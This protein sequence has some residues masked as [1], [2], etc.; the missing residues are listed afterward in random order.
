MKKVAI[1]PR[2]FLAALLLSGL[3]SFGAS[4]AP[5]SA[6]AGSIQE[7]TRFV[8]P[9]REETAP[10]SAYV[11]P[12]T[13]SAQPALKVALQGSAPNARQPNTPMLASC[14]LTVL[15]QDNSTSGNERAPTLRNR[16]ARSVYLI[17]AAELAANGLS[18]GAT[19]TGIGWDYQTAQGVTGSGPLVVYMQNT[20]DVTNTKSTTWA[21]AITGMTTVHNATTTLPSPAGTFDIP[22]SGGSPFTYTGGGIYV[23]F[24]FQYPVGTLST[25]TVVWCNSTGLVNGLL[26]NQSNASAPTTLAASSF[27]PETRL[28]ATVPDND[29]SVDVI[30]SIGT[31]AIGLEQPH[32][33]QAVITNKG[34]T[35]ISNLPVTLSI[36]GAESFTDTQVIPSL[37]A[38]GGQTTVSFAAFTPAVQ[39]SDVVTVSVPSDD[40]PA[41]NTKTRPLNVTLP[42]YSY[43]YPGSVMAGGFGFTGATGAFVAKFSTTAPAKITDVNLEFAG[44]NTGYRVAIYAN[45]GGPGV[46]G[47]LVYLDA[48]N[49][50]TGGAGPVTATLS[51]PVTIGPG[52]FFVGIH[53]MNTT[54]ANL[55]FDLEAPIRAG[56]F[57]LGTN[58][59]ATNPPGTWTDFFPGNNFK[60]NIGIVLDRCN[61][62]PVA[63]NNGPLC[64]GATLQLTASAAGAATYSWTGP[65]A[66]PRISRTRRSRTRPA[67]TPVSTR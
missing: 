65:T 11:G 35:S 59:V 52:D 14:V 6:Q 19:I 50:T 30:A 26:G 64:N 20:S 57:F 3:G 34:G 2:V 10:G 43:K 45:G 66:S 18:N 13:M 9:P 62:T 40:V 54:N 38:C 4:F 28:T 15:P 23:A 61:I 47:A 17:T 1:L 63:S 8:V 29:A 53:Q 36:S 46:P 55:G 42:L 31:F 7:T 41:N 24:D 5:A 48:A 25:T 21:T 67:R 39:G 22:F 58:T 33:I 32:V 27:R 37:S 16:F 12:G 44:A 60:P 49:R 56:Q 51:S